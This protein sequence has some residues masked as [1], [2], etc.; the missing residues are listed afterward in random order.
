MDNTTK[1]NKKPNVK[2][3]GLKTKKD[4]KELKVEKGHKL[5]KKTPN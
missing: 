4:N 3:Y 2:V 5:A 1:K